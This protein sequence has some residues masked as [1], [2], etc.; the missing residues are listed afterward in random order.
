M[1]KKVHNIAVVVLNY[2]CA[3][4][5]I[6]CCNS[7]LQQQGVEFSLI[8]V[9]N[10]SED[11][12]VCFFKSKLPLAT[13]IE[14]P[15]N[16]G[17]AAGNNLGI[18]RAL[19]S[20]G[21]CTAIVIANPD[22]EFRDAF[23]LLNLAEGLAKNREIVACSPLIRNPES[24]FSVDPREAIQVRRVPDF[25]MVLISHSWWL[26][27]IF[28]E[29]FRRYTYGDLRPFAKNSVVPVETINGAC[30][31]I[32]PDFIKENQM[33]DKSTFLYHEEIILGAQILRAKRLCGLVT[34][35]VVLHYQGTSTGEGEGRLLF[36]RRLQALKSECY[37]C[38][39]YQDAGLVK[40]GLL[41][42]T[43][44]IDVVTKGIIFIVIKAFR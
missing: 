7:I 24:N 19:E 41:C 27:R 13:L 6:R 11:G 30:F 5:T 42:V 4:A 2:K 37:Y 1:L 25:P 40:L 18:A 34:N 17:Y 16:L 38:L 44:A 35:S 8:V 23:A 28:Q 22:L 12:S 9:D 31:M 32:R 14:A 21:D 20:A 43:R 3:D 15:K 36:R 10:H 39:K 26:S 33:L 29:K